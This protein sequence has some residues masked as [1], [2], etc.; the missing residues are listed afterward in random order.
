MFHLLSQAEAYGYHV[1]VG[2]LPAHRLAGVADP[3]LLIRPDVFIGTLLCLYL[4]QEVAE[5]AGRKEVFE[6][7]Q[8]KSATPC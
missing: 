8:A 7:S 5:I 2:D 6:R 3:F 4:T 1:S